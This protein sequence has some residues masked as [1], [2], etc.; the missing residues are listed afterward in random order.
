MMHKDFFD[1]NQLIKLTGD[2]V[3]LTLHDIVIL[4][5]TIGSLYSLSEVRM[6]SPEVIINLHII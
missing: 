2:E 3:E 5:L 1:E 4:F 6:Q